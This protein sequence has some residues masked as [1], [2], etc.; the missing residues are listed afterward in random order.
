[1]PRI[2]AGVEAV[3]LAVLLADLLTTHTPAVTAL[4]G[5]VHGTAYLMVVA[6]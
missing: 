3:S 5:P 1:M 6:T 2:S 4:V